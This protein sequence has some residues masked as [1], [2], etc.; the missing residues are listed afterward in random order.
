MKTLALGAVLLSTL[1][2]TS[3]H[4]E[5]WSVLEATLK[6][7]NTTE[8]EYRNGST[9]LKEKKNNDLE[10]NDLGIETLTKANGKIEI[11]EYESE[12]MATRTISIPVA[13][14]ILSQGLNLKYT[15]SN[16]EMAFRSL[17]G[18]KLSDVMGKYT[19]AEAS[20]GLIGNLGV[21]S[22][23]NKKGVGITDFIASLGVG[24]KYS[25]VEIGVFASS[26]NDI[27]INTFDTAGIKIED[28]NVS[29]NDIENHEFN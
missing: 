25:R 28:R 22:F 15:N 3:V 20:I 21:R 11:V 29:L 17:R 26:P 24:V 9:Y 13:V 14:R 19:G 16:G 2:T 27:N 7:T 23:V 8:T 6:V 5:N 12:T 1:I 4:A 10:E 18:K